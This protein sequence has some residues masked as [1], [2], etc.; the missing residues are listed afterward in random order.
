MTTNK[1]VLVWE[2]ISLLTFMQFP[3]RFFTFAHVFLAILSGYA[4]LLLSNYKKLQVI[5]VCLV[6]VAFAVLQA[7]F[8]L[9]EKF[10]TN[11]DEFY[12]TDPDYIQRELSKT[13]NDYLPKGIETRGFPEPYPRL[14]G[15][16]E[17][18]IEVIKNTPTHIEAVASCQKPCG[19]TVGIF[20][21]PG[22]RVWIN[23]EEKTLLVNPTF[24][25]YQLPL[26]SGFSSIRIQLTDT[27]IRKFANVVSIVSVFVLLGIGMKDFRWKKLWKK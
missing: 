23:G 21:F 13:L 14:T 3:W 25:V 24:P 7:R 27:P 20:T 10:I 15:N 2:R 16:S 5:S 26:P 8:F 11:T 1:S 19:I 18:Q 22:W 4:I 12:R 9:P 6:F 17:T